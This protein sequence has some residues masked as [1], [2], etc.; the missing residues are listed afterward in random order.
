MHMNNHPHMH[1]TLQ[2]TQKK[3]E[4]MHVY[5]IIDHHN[6]YSIYTANCFQWYRKINIKSLHTSLSGLEN[7]KQHATASIN[8]HAN[9]RERERES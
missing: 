9:W 7:I 5:I 2:C 8:A 6:I 4:I 1:K 3:Q